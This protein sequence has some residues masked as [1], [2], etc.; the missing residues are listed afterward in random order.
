MCLQ[1]SV[2]EEWNL[3]GG[4]AWKGS[5]GTRRER[6]SSTD[7]QHK[8]K[9]IKLATPGWV[10][11]AASIFGQPQGMSAQQPVTPS[12]PETAKYWNSSVL[13]WDLKWG[14]WHQENRAGAGTAWIQ[15]SP[16][17]GSPG[18][19]KSLIP[20]LARIKPAWDCLWLQ[21]SLGSN[22]PWFSTT[23]N[24][25]MWVLTQSMVTRATQDLWR[26]RGNHSSPTQGRIYSQTASSATGEADPGTG[27]ILSATG[28][29]PEQSITRCYHTHTRRAF[30]CES[31]LL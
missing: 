11:S 20:E 18:A 13:L 29:I 15:L 28:Y 1:L 9:K 5:L 10:R 30:L 21:G 12:I 26:H 17:S 2:E 8:W 4:G 23:P 16:Y 22:W 27:Q 3:G 24:A 6:H 7:L 25:E 19:A 14:F 31:S